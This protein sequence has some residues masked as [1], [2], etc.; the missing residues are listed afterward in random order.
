VCRELYF[1][2]LSVESLNSESR[3]LPVCWLS[4]LVPGAQMS[5]D[6][7]GLADVFCDLLSFFCYFIVCGGMMRRLGA[8]KITM[9]SRISWSSTAFQWVQL[10][11]NP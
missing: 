9:T 3:R 1:L 7:P 6:G 11:T 8:L 2:Y 4:A 5:W 10:F